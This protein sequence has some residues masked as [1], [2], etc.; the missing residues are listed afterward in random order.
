MDG[1]R[2]LLHWHRKL[3]TWM[4]PGGHIEEEEEPIEA[5]LRE[6]R[7]ETALEAEVVTEFREHDF[8]SPRQLPPPRVILV[9]DIGGP[10]PDHQHIDLIYFCRS[11]GPALGFT[12]DKEMKQR[13]VSLQ[14]L[15]DCSGLELDGRLLPIAD[16][17]RVLAIEAILAVRAAT[18]AAA[19]G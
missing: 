4:P 10:N 18:P 9:E 15:E 3:D 6:I 5:L 13:W 14:E 12:A 19:A 16:D 7:E 1:E 8:T 11:L 17:V 2:T